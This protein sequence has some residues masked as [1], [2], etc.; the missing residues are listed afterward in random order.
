MLTYRPALVTVSS[1]R[2]CPGVAYR[3]VCHRGETVA[4]CAPGGQAM[5]GQPGVTVPFLPAGRPAGARRGPHPLGV[6]SMCACPS[7][8]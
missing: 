4:A 2:A 3:P 1:A 7:Y 8:L 5:P 6:P